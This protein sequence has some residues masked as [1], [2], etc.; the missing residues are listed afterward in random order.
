MK[1]SFISILTPVYNEEDNIHHIYDQVKKEMLQLGKKYDYEHIFSDNSSI[2]NSLSILKNIHLRDKKVKIIS[3]TKNFGVTKS[4]LNGLYK[5]SGDA[6]IQIDAD[7]QDPPSMILKFINEWEKGNMVVYGIRTDRDENPFMKLLR[8][9]FYRIA[10]L[11]SN[12]NLIPDVGEFRLI[13]KAII[14]ELKKINNYNPYLRGIIANM[15]FKQV[16]IPYHRD[17]RYKGNSSTNFYKLFDYGI[18]GIISHSSIL[19]RLATIVGCFLSIISFSL[20][21]LYAVLKVILPNSPPGLTTLN[22]FILFFSGVQM[23]FLGIIG[24]YIAKIF[25]QSIDRPIVIEEELIGFDKHNN[26]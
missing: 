18:N 13:D 9:G 19:L 21:V 24:E 2:D 8:K 4:T 25:D 22:I 17:Q 5:C 6:I 23:I 15:G 20:I 1:K 10:N 11:L 7:L 26:N 14:L 3:L 16:G 12:E